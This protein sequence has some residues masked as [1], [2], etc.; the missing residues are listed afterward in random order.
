MTTKSYKF[1]AECYADA[2]TALAKLFPYVSNFTVVR[3]RGDN[4][5]FIPDVEVKIN[6]ILH[7]DS[8]MD[9]LQKVKDGHVMYQTVKPLAEYTG[10]RDY[11]IKGN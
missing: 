5:N 7:P 11:D 2:A 3:M 9:I 4:G 1:R 10:E 6:T 8:L